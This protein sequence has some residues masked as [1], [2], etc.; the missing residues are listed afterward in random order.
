ME[1]ARF[2]VYNERLDA[3]SAVY[4][5]NVQPSAAQ[6]DTQ[7]I[8]IRYYCESFQANLYRLVILVFAMCQLQA[9]Q[10]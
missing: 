3:S 10:L 7:Y 9:M 5:L 8:V 2:D 6:R 1:V 4:T